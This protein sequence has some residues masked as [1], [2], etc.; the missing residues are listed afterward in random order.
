MI[1]NRHMLS[2]VRGHHEFITEKKFPIEKIKR[3]MNFYHSID[4]MDATPKEKQWAKKR[5]SR[6]LNNMIDYEIEN[7]STKIQLKAS[8]KSKDLWMKFRDSFND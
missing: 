3:E 1:Y 4:A 7:E 5:L 6:R 2:N 8:I